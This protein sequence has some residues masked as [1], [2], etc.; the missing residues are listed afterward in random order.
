[1]SKEFSPLPQKR[2]FKINFDE[3]QT[4]D[5]FADLASQVGWKLSVVDH[6]LEILR[7]PNVLGT[8]LDKDD[9]IEYVQLLKESPNKE[10]VLPPAFRRILNFQACRSAIMFGDHL[11]KKQ[12]VALIDSLAKC[13]S[14]FQCAHGRPT[15]APL[16]SYQLLSQN[17]SFCKAV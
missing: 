4:L 11:D 5:Q 7:A 15:V 6:T 2:S 12:C 8:T 13:K 16:A 3:K 17:L 9:L 1:M 14:P 10:K